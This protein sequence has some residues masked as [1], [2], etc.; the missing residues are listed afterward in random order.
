MSFFIIFSFLSIG[1]LSFLSLKPNKLSSEIIINIPK[2]SS[3]NYITDL[4]YEQKIIKNKFTFKS[5]SFLLNRHNKL[6]AGEYLIELADNNM[7]IIE[8]LYKNEIYLH[9]IIIPEGYSNIQVFEKLNK[10]NLIL[11]TVNEHYNEGSFFPD[12]YFYSRDTKKSDLLKNMHILA[13]NKYNKIY[14]DFENNLNFNKE[15]ILIIASMVEAEA[16]FI[17]EKRKIASVFYNRLKL[18]MRMQSDPTIIYGINKTI[19]LDRKLSKKDILMDHPWNTY[20]IDGLPPTPICNFGIESLIA[21]IN[22]DK[23]EYLYF[24]ADGKGGHY[25]SKTYDQHLNYIKILKEK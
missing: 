12:T 13:N 14:S 11:D 6:K 24:V 1:Y 4:L 20:R 5:Y 22:P 16:K 23:S 7:T 17:K 18:G 25:F 3:L 10:S 9:Q 19:Y 21:A 15:Q 2:N 8:K